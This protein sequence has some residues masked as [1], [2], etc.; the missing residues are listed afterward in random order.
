[1]TI[2]AALA[3]TPAV[4]LGQAA[5]TIDVENPVLLPGE[6]TVVT[7]W[8]G[9]GGTDYA[10]A[11]VSGDLLTSVGSTGFSDA[12]IL[13]PMT[14]PRGVVTPGEPTGRGFEGFLAN[15]LNFHDIRADPSNPI[16]FWRATYTAPLDP[17]AP[18]DIDL[19]TVTVRYDVYIRRDSASSESRLADLVE[20]SGTIRVVP[21]PASA[22][23][24][25]VG[26]LAVRRRR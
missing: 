8:A 4:A 24:L 13:D 11:G 17:E 3:A 16:A 25:G 2:A 22:V 10:V 15:Q 19:S 20:G 6:S 5:I 18:F 7:L 9:Y 12:T 26:V 21:A 1:M 14:V 23:L